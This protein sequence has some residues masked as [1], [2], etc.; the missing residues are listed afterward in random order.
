M[1]SSVLLLL[2]TGCNAFCQTPQL[3]FTFVELDLQET[4]NTYTTCDESGKPMELI[5]AMRIDINGRTCLENGLPVYLPMEKAKEFKK[6]TWFRWDPSAKTW[7]K[8]TLPSNY[9]LPDG[10]SGFIV[11]LNCPGIYAFFEPIQVSTNKIEFIAPKKM[12]VVKFKISQEAP[13][14]CLEVK[15]KKDGEFPIIPFGELKFDARITLTY[16]EKGKEK[17]IEMLAG[18]MNDLENASEK[19]VKTLQ[20]KPNK[21]QT[22]LSSN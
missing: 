22:L 17:T 15:S 9:S 12:H 8:Q 16:L 19:N 6:P 20:Y 11:I 2:L 21:T 5:S 14:I 7:K 3:P 1:K 13:F 4:A 18:A 10:K